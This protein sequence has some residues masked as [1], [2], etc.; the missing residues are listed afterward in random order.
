MIHFLK[1]FLFALLVILSNTIYAQAPNKF[2]YQAVIRDADNQL[3]V[4]ANVGFR[5]SILLNSTTGSLVYEEE[6]MVTT[7]ENGLAT[8]VIG[9]GTVNFGSISIIQWELN[10]YYLKTEID[11]AGGTNYSLTGTTQLLS[12]PYA[13]S[14]SNGFSLSLSDDNDYRTDRR[15]GILTDPSTTDYNI[16][17]DVAGKTKTTQLQVT[18]NASEGKVLTSDATGNASWQ[19]PFSYW[20]FST[21][22]S[23]LYPSVNGYMGFG[24][25]YSPLYPFHFRNPYA[26]MALESTDPNSGAEF[27]IIAAQDKKASITFA[28]G[29]ANTLWGMGVDENDKFYFWRNGTSNAMTIDWSNNVGIGNYNPS[30]RLS[31]SGNADISGNLGLGY[32]T[33]TNKL[34]VNGGADFNGNVGIGVTNPSSPLSFPAAI[35]NK[36]LLYPGASGFAGLGVYSNEVRLHSDN[37]NGKVSFGWQDN[38]G[39]YTEFGKFHAWNNERLAVFGTIWANGTTYA[40]DERFKKN[41]KSISNP[42]EKLL[43]INGVEYEMNTDKFPSMNF[44]SDRQMGFLAQNV[45][46]VVPEAVNENEDGYKGVDYARLVPLLLESI[47]EQQKQI[48]L[49][50]KRIEALEGK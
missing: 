6:Q 31:V 30:N 47:K 10:D 4:N 17:L 26:W 14:A 27:R 49:L 43:Q 22:N 35:G 9:N 21:T 33:P 48:E 1:K 19:N 38:S 42:I 8:L 18:H 13:L 40:S 36:I 34:S 2:S 29:W 50:E 3:L 15:I 46:K 12:V 39:N 32:T 25:S 24:S 45:E 28:Q 5:I 41:I 11:P 23:S 44:Q 16:K 20:N 37:L 7:N